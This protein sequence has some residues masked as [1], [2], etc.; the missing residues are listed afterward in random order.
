[1]PLPAAMLFRFNKEVYCNRLENVLKTTSHQSQYCQGMNFIAAVF[2]LMDF[3]SKE[4]FICLNY[5]LRQCY[6]EPLFN[7]K[8]SSLMEYMAIFEHKFLEQDSV[9]YHHLQE[10]N[11]TSICYAIEWFTTCFIVPCP[12][13]LSYLV[14]DLLM[15]GFPDIMIRVGLA[16]MQQLRDQLL[17]RDQEG[18]MSDFKGLCNALNPIHVVSIALTYEVLENG[19]YLEVGGLAIRSTRYVCA[20]LYPLLPLPPPFLFPRRWRGISS[21]WTRVPGSSWPPP[22]AG[23]G[24]PRP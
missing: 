11:F 2:I 18:L 20:L 16:I 17:G 4:V 21:E 7:A 23:S 3:T 5:L 12:G 13:E 24:S 14:I 1:M 6:L 10:M 22:L 19:N 8:A 9:L 15:A